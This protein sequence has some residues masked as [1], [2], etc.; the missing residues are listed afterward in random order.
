MKKELG[1][2]MDAV[3]YRRAR[4]IDGRIVRARV[5]VI[6]NTVAIR[7]RKRPTRGWSGGVLAIHRVGAGLAVALEGE[8]AQWEHVHV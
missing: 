5:I 2:R 1:G 3:R 7:V 6:G 4:T 8:G